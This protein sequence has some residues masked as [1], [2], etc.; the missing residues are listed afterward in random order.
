MA[1]AVFLACDE[2]SDDSTLIYLL[3]SSAYTELR[4]FQ[5][6][7]LLCCEELGVHSELR[8]DTTSTAVPDW[9]KRTDS[10]H[11]AVLSNKI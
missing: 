2:N 1:C 10:L 6:L 3:V 11:E 5:L 4:T 8:G 9:R 7:T